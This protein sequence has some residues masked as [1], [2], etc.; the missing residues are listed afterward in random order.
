MTTGFVHRVLP[1]GL[2]FLEEM[3]FDLRLSVS[4]TAQRI[5]QRLD[6]EAWVR[7]ANPTMILQNAHQDRLNELA[8]DPELIAD[9]EALRR[10]YL[11]SLTDPGWYVKS[12]GSSKL[13]GVAYFSMEFGLSEALPIYSGGLG[14]LAGDHLKSA[15][16]LNVP[17]VG[18]GLLYQQGYFRQVLAQDGW[19]TQAF[20][21]NDPASLP[22]QPVL[23]G[24][25]RWPRIRLE[26]PGRVLLLRVWQAKVGR[27]ALYLLDSNHPLNSPSDRGI[28]ANLYAAGRDKR[29]LQ[30]LV[31]GIGGWRLLEKLGMDPPVCHLNEGH[32]AFL[33]LARAASFAVRHE[34]SFEV[35]LR[36]TRPGNV[37]TTHTPVEAAFDVFDPDLVS[38]LALPLLGGAGLGVEQ[39]LAMGRRNP[40]DPGEPFNMAY[41]AFRGSGSVNGVARLHGAVSRRLFASLFPRRPEAEVPVDHVTNG[42]HVPTWETAPAQQ[43]WAG[44]APGLTPWIERLEEAGRAIEQLP[45]ETLWD[46]RASSRRRLVD[47]VRGRLERQLRERGDPEPHVHRAKHVLDANALTI[48]LARRF[49]TYKR[50]NLI[51]EDPE[52][53]ARL[54]LHPERPVQLVLAGKAHPNDD[55][56]K[57]M[58]RS[59]VHFAWR[60]D[61][62]DRVVF[63]ED[64]DITLAQHLTAG[65]DLWLNVPRRP[66]EACGT[67]GM[68]ILV[69]GGLHCSTKDGWWDEAYAPEVGWAIGGEREHHGEGD[70]DDA[71]ELYETL[72]R[73]IV[74]AFYDRDESGLPKSWIRRIRS[75]MSR[76]TFR[77]DS[78]RMVR[79]YVEKKYLPAAEAYLRRAAD[80]A[81][82]S[83]ELEAWRQR[84]AEGWEGIRFGELRVKEAEGHWRH[85]L[86]VY[87]GDLSPHEIQVELFAGGSD[88]VCLPMERRSSLPGAVNGYLFVATAPKDRPSDHYTPRITAW[89]PDAILPIEDPRVTWYR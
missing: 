64:Y 72:E 13:S 46:F 68:K 54:L 80:G 43:L 3:A 1:Y 11:K 50:P 16:D 36:A 24:D 89:H 31:L 82:L 73:E 66:A 71:R 81:R 10:R 22:V 84:T 26:L 56:G 19:Q 5:W 88:P 21:F 55:G 60:D 57:E 49:A 7:S 77:F 37:F 15:S 51:L 85:E 2:E 74:P 39:L 32:A 9:L 29:L 58:I 8:A 52:R 61:M 27:V 35:A 14:I 34:V 53:L 44:S 25:G 48:G 40:S 62:R 41:L 12:H 63:L 76:L 78:G 28:T 42:I 87:L 69:N 75:S 17:V 70:S 45:D 23:D 30:E 20:P 18:I 38:R 83:R 67:S 59:I 4:Q 47:Y 79:E 33:V 6:P 65:V 86:Q